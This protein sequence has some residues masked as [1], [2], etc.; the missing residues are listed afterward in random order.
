[1]APRL[2]Y[3]EII[4][5]LAQQQPTKPTKK[6]HKKLRRSKPE[7]PLVSPVIL[8]SFTPEQRRD[9]CRQALYGEDPK[10]RARAWRLYLL[11]IRPEIA[12]LAHNLGIP[13]QQLEK[14]YQTYLVAR[15]DV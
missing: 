15:G 10:A 12:I 4:A 14:E 1:M 2:T 13:Q 6:R 7:S 3:A 5:R 9:L 11:C 8:A